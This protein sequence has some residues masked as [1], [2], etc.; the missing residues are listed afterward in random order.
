VRGLAP[1]KGR[2]VFLEMVQPF[3]LEVHWGSSR[4]LTSQLQLLPDIVLERT[5]LLDSD[6]NYVTLR[7]RKVIR[8]NNP[9]PGH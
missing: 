4:L 3:K 1:D 9:G 6:P 5:N 8:R 2:R 7:Q